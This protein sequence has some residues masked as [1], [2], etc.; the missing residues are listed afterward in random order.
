MNGR[1]RNRG[2]RGFIRTWLSFNEQRPL[3]PRLFWK[4]LAAILTMLAV[5]F[6]LVA[7]SEIR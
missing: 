7:V 1:D 5:C 6:L 2:P 3:R 4:F